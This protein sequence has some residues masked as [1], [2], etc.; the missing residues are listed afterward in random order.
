MLAAEAPSSVCLLFLIFSSPAH[1]ILCL[2]RGR[3][4]LQCLGS[5]NQSPCWVH[6]TDKPVNMLAMVDA[7]LAAEPEMSPTCLAG[8]QDASGV[9]TWCHSC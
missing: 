2:K 4:K 9:L 8:A 3:T 1:P 5:Q 6:L 7:G